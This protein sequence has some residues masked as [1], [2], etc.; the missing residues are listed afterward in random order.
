MIIESGTFHG[1]VLCASATDEA[2]W[3][4][5]ND[6]S[7]AYCRW[8]VFGSDGAFTLY[9][10]AKDQVMAYTG[11]NEGAVVLEDQGTSSLGAS[12]EQWSWG[13]WEDWGARALR[14]CWDDGQNVDARAT[15]GDYPRTDGVHTRGWRH[16]YQRELTWN[17][18]AVA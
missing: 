17:V 6:P 3:L 1:Y 15:D 18:T 9:N 10:P 16:G 12:G 14:T 11:G 8:Q 7:N 5:P 4:K 13:G 2:V